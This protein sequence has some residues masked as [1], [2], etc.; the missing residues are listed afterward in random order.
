MSE[1]INSFY[2]VLIETDYLASVFCAVLDIFSQSG[3][4]SFPIRL[5]Q[6]FNIFFSLFPLCF[7]AIIRLSTFCLF[8]IYLRWKRQKKAIK[9]CS[10]D[11][12]F[13][14]IR[15][16]KGMGWGGRKQQTNL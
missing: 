13:L 3:C 6:Y 10:E 7:P 11:Y 4:F 5:D 12:F 1:V 8:A 9:K 14:N 16:H 2:N 15:K